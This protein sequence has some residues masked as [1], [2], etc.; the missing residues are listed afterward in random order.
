MDM[1]EV[2][3]VFDDGITAGLIIDCYYI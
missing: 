1:K 2:S 3:K